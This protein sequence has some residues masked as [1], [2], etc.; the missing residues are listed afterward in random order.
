[1]SY[2]AKRLK[3]GLISKTEEVT[4]GFVKD[5]QFDEEYFLVVESKENN[6][7]TGLKDRKMIAVDDIDE[8]VHIDGFQFQIFYSDTTQPT[9][10]IA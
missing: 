4:I 1:M 6:P 10:K 9:D 8:I 5:T 7:K 2:S 3:S